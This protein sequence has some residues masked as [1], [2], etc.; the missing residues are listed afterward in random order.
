MIMSVDVR[1]VTMRGVFCL[2]DLVVGQ[3]GCMDYPIGL[4]SQKVGMA[5]QH[6]EHH[7]ES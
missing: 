2:I 6:Q 4:W 7:K 5:H 1:L 3:E